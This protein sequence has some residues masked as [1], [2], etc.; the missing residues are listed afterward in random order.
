MALELTFEILLISGIAVGYHHVKP[1]FDD[2][3]HD[4]GSSYVLSGNQFG[5]FFTCETA[6]PTRFGNDCS[7]CGLCVLAAPSLLG[8]C[9]L[10]GMGLEGSGSAIAFVVLRSWLPVARLCEGA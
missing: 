8:W 3:F 7:T 9:L 5:N 2:S 10:L 1:S 6:G 4:R